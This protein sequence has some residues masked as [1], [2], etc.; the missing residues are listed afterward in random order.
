VSAGLPGLGLGG[1]FFIFSALL[2]P[3]RELWRTWRGQS[4]PGDWRMAGRQFAQAATMVAAIDLSLRLVYAGLAVAG[5]GNPPSALSETVIPVTLI[6]ITS[7]L[8]VV[9]LAAAKLADISARLRAGGLPQV[10]PTLP[11]PTP[12][13]ALALGGAVAIAWA[14]LLT[15]GASELSPLAPP[16]GGSLV[17]ETRTEAQPRS[18]QNPLGSR[19]PR[20]TEASAASDANVPGRSHVRQP[21]AEE[22]H[23]TTGDR[24]EGTV[25]PPTPAAAPPSTSAPALEKPTPAAASPNA[26]SPPA[27]AAPANGPSPA[28]NPP[29]ETGLPPTA[30]PPAGPPAHE[31]TGPPEHAEG[32]PNHPAPAR[33]EEN[34]G[35][36]AHSQAASRS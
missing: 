3:F 36:P 24:L 17:P 18:A 30:P 22:G 14:A 11:R 35:P 5:I 34:P 13:R 21:P 28:A 29:Q 1:L 10:P 31:Q 20:R 6:G 2:A 9:V 15:A 27:S 7:A 12:L 25:Q 16:P 8:L 4:R 33:P 26:D 19:G 23:G 32:P